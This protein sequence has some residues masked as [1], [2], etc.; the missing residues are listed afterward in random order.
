MQKINEF[1][2]YS[3]FEPTGD[4]PDAIDTLVKGIRN[5]ENQTLLGVTGVEK[6]S[7]LPMPLPKLEK[8]HL[9]SHITKLLLHNF[10]Q[11]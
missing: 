1:K 3:D 5:K 9:L 6:H 11:N 8:M 7:Q 2:L 10:I 4:Q